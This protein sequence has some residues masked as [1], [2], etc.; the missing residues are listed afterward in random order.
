MG[1]YEIIPIFLKSVYAFLLKGT[2]NI[3][4]DCGIPG[5]EVTILKAMAEHGVES[6]ALSLILITHGHSDHMGAVSALRGITGAQTAIHQAD[7][8]VIRTG[9]NPSLH[10]QSRLGS[11][12]A[13]VIGEE[14]KGFS[15][16][17]PE[18]LIDGEMSLDGFGIPGK[19]LMTP[20][21]TE[22]SVSVLLNSGEMFIGDALM[23]GMLTRGKPRFPVYADNVDKANDSIRRIVSLNPKILCTGHGGP[24]T[25]D[26]VKS[27]FKG[28]F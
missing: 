4:I 25:V 24:F 27:S 10:A 18:L 8:A 21:H 14:I 22:G 5:S 23:G 20:G 2:K 16:Y 7:A 17:E 6:G 15:P 19:V 3:L 13:A 9:K 11:L 12:F 28:R 26:E 1:N